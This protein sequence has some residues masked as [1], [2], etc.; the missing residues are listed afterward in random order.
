MD[1]FF[2]SKTTHSALF[3]DYEGLILL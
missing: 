3:L 1:S 2:L